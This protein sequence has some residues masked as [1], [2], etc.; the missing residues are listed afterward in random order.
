[1]GSRAQGLFQE[2]NITVITGAQPNDPDVVIED[3]LNDRL[4]VGPNACDH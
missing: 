1:M 4:D 3:F 2:A